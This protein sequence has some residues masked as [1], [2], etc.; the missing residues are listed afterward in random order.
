MA[1][2]R[3]DVERQDREEHQA[4]DLR[5]AAPHGPD[6][7]PHVRQDPNQA[8]HPREAQQAEVENGL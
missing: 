5:H 6:E 8:R 3:V 1:D 4:R 2:D 7:Q